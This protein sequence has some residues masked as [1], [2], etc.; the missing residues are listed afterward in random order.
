MLKLLSPKTDIVFQNLFG[1]I[2][3]EEITKRL[4]SLIMNKEIQG[5]NL[6][7]SNRLEREL[8]SEKLGLLDVRAK[9]KSGEDV[10]IEMQIKD[11]KDM[12]QRM[13]YYWSKL[14]GRKLE[15]SEEYSTLRPTVSILITEY[16]L[17]ETKDILNYHTI[18]NL[19]E[20]KR[21]DKII[22]RN[23]ELHIIELP[24]IKEE[25][26]E[27]DA[28]IAWLMFIKNPESERVRG[29][30]EEDEVLKQA[31]KELEHLSGSENFQRMVELR[32]K[33]IRDEISEKA[34]ARREG[35]E[36]GEAEGEKT[37]SIKIARKLLKE[38]M[39]IERICKI[40]ELERKEIESLREE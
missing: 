1:K 7:V 6:D 36:K 33:A 40:T 37:A 10:N 23:I 15:R 38:K 25:E 22:S 17:K 12:S 20:E 35:R 4:L 21:K 2:G 29:K 19:R 5:L 8:V 27:K 34:E 14:Y 11:N 18:W 39:P 3:N 30:M 28:L 31:M 16:C 24:K 13:L 32:E 9:L 26:I